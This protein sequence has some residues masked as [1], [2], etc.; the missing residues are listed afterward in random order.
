MCTFV[1]SVLAAVE[2][3]IEHVAVMVSHMAEVMA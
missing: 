2:V 1:L 3:V